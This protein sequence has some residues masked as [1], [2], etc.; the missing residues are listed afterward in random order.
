MIQV[1]E[2]IPLWGIRRCISAC[3]GLRWNRDHNAAINI[4]N[5]L[6]PYLERG[7]WPEEGEE[8]EEEDDDDAA[9]TPTGEI[10]RATGVAMITNATHPTATLT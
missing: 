7:T 10:V 6:L 8:E 5:N 1:P 2:M 3:G 4:R 9:S